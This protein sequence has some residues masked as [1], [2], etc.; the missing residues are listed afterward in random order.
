VL[1]LP[2][3]EAVYLAAHRAADPPCAAHHGRHF[4]ERVRPYCAADPV[5]RRRGFAGVR[6]IV[7]D[8]HAA[9]GP[10]VRYRLDLRTG[11]L[12]VDSGP[13]SERNEIGARGEVRPD[14]VGT[15][16]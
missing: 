9:N 1:H 13:S 15:M 12:V 16:G 7:L 3:G 4:A 6:T 11:E 14:I 5:P 10:A 2:T 8:V